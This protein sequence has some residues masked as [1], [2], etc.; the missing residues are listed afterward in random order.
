MSGQVMVPFNDIMEEDINDDLERNDHNREQEII[1]E[2]LNLYFI[3]WGYSC[4]GIENP[5]QC[6]EE[7]L[8]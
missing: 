1:D 8:T 5:K 4:L 3:L 2:V 7:R 6:S